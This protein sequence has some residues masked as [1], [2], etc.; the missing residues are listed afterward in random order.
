MTCRVFKGLSKYIEEEWQEETVLFMAR[1]AE[2]S[3]RRDL[4]GEQARL[5]LHTSDTLAMVF[6]LWKLKEA[7][8]L[9]Q[10]QVSPMLFKPREGT[11]SFLLCLDLW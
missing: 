11:E 4:E 10:E 5:L 3:D 2:H 7:L 9:V 6:F 1:V 8:V